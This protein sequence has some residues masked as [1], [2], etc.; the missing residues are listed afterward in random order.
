MSGNERR[1]AAEQLAKDAVVR[2]MKV[3]PATITKAGWLLQLP[4]TSEKRKDP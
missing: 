2:L 3:D 1:A 4:L